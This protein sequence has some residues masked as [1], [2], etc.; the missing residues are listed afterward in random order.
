[1]RQFKSTN[2]IKWIAFEESGAAMYSIK[3]DA[4]W[5]NE[6]NVSEL[7]DRGFTAL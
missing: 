6:D 3:P 1:L 4:R 2:V 5:K 7:N